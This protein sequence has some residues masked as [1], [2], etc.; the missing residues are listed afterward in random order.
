MT[1]KTKS[2]AKKPPN[3]KKSKPTRAEASRIN[4]AKSRGPK[5][6]AGKD[7]IRHN[8]VK[9]GLT[10]RSTLLPGEDPVAYEFRRLKFAQST[11]PQN[12]LEAMLTD[13]MTS[14][15]WGCER[16]ENAMTA[17]VA[18]E[19][20]TQTLAQELAD[21]AQVIEWS[22][23]LFLDIRAPA[24]FEAEV[25]EGG[26]G[27]A[28][29]LVMMLQSTVAG[30]DWLLERYGKLKLHLSAPDAW[31]LRDGFELIRLLGHY[32]GDLEGEQKVGLVLLAS[33]IAAGECP[34]AFVETPEP[35]STSD[36][37][38]DAQF[39]VIP[40]R[41]R[42]NRN[43]GCVDPEIESKVDAFDRANALVSAAIDLS[44][45]H[46]LGVDVPL[47]DRSVP[48]TMAD[49]RRRLAA[50]IA[51][52]MA[53]LEEIRA[54]R[55][56]MAEASAAEATARL[57][58][59]TSHEGSLLKRYATAHGRMFQSAINTFLKVRKAYSDGTL[60][61]AGETDDADLIAQAEQAARG[62]EQTGAG[63]AHQSAATPKPQT[64]SYLDTLVTQTL[65][66]PCPWELEPRLRNKPE[67]ESSVSEKQEPPQPKPPPSPPPPM[68]VHVPSAP[69]PPAPPIPTA[70][71]AQPRPVSPPPPSATAPRPQPTPP[72]AP[73]APSPGTDQPSRHTAPLGN[74]ARAAP[75]A[76][77][78]SLAAKVARLR[79]E[80]RYWET[81][82]PPHAKAGWRHLPG[83]SCTGHKD[84]ERY[85]RMLDAEFRVPT[86]ER[87]RHEYGCEP[88]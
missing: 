16:V 85:Q 32:V 56:R 41:E 5:T 22:T 73:T 76:N 8:A 47:L 46:K 45:P 42:A 65:H 30:C 61:P 62:A 66:T 3:T 1:T 60:E 50:V 69:P 43:G 88:P 21:G 24:P 12:A 82:R 23:K 28:R 79:I 19:L 44:D 15:S 38:I 34:P 40:F 39:D 86:A 27:H 59:F 84:Y 25:R 53:R 9:H 75:T 55:V 72:P 33:N 80:E 2:T 49:A 78:E 64:P 48:L 83:Q 4:G 31:R 29:W 7:K 70:Q 11:N 20:R 68:N 6:E 10:A 35:K 52:E 26:P 58:G 81:E 13:R 67:K 54:H 51:D 17:H 37:E 18:H 74:S 14:E 36:S 57:A 63:S 77:Q 71:P 87:F